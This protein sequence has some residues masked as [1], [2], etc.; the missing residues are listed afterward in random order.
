MDAEMID[1]LREPDFAVRLWGYDRQQVDALLAELHKR[2]RAGELQPTEAEA[3]ESQLTGIGERVEAILAAATDAASHVSEEASAK[4]ASLTRETE[5]AAEHQRREADSYAK[6]A[7]TDA[8]QYV[9]RVRSDADRETA[10][11]RE[12]ARTEA[13]ATIAAAEEEADTIVREA[14]LERGRIEEAIEALRER[15][16]LVIASIERMRGNLGSMVGEAEQG[17]DA[18]VAMGDD[19][20]DT[21]VVFDEQPSAPPPGPADELED[22][23][24]G[25]PIAWDEEALPVD[26]EFIA[27]DDRPENGVPVFDV[28]TLGAERSVDELFEDPDRTAII[29][30]GEPGFEDPEPT[31]AFDPDQAAAETD[32][33]D[34][35]EREDGSARGRQ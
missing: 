4:A 12:Q 30:T 3:I 31:E 24:G 9:A 8:D 20:D 10:Q 26:G 29:D 2:A 27:D 21:R 28:G 34:V 15:R 6:T 32:E 35:V 19:P 16:E 33:Q 11:L 22:I 1:R 23:E 25:E 5:Q 13:D 14:H 18:F 17:T 7:R